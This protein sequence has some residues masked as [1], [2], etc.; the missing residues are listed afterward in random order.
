MKYL[1]ATPRLGIRKLVRADAEALYQLHANQKVQEFTGKPVISSFEDIT[2][3]VRKMIDETLTNYK[4]YGYGRWMVTLKESGQVI[5]WNGLV[6]RENI[7]QVDLGY[8]F[9]PDYWGNG[10]ATESSRAILDYGLH[11]LGLS[12]IIAI[13]MKENTSSIRVLEKVGMQFDHYEDFMGY[14]DAMWYCI[15]K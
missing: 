9:H 4:K 5:G 3:A 13:T 2:N 1:I 14:K 7:G 8:R 11:E 15:R 12:Q 10:Y 6:Y